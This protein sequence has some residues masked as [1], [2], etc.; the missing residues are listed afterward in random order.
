[1]S[2]LSAVDK[3]RS[4]KREITPLSWAETERLM[5]AAEGDPFEA[6]Y[7]L[8]VLHGLR[9]GELLGL[10]WEHVDLGRRTVRVAGTATVDHEGNRVVTP[11]KTDRARRTLE[12]SDRCLNALS[13]TPRHGG[14]VWPAADGK[15][16]A[17]S[18]FYKRW[19]HM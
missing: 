12:L 18:T 1:S 4:R 6:A 19:L 2:A 11:P 15:P 7:A 14:L 10:R 8:A 3:P 9:E 17:R 13:R 5:E 16:M